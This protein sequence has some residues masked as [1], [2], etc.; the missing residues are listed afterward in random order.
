MEILIP[1]L[2]FRAQYLLV[3]FARCCGY[4]VVG[5]APAF[6]AGITGS[7]PVT[8]SMGSNFLSVGDHLIYKTITKHL[9]YWEV[10]QQRGHSRSFDVV[11]TADP[12][13]VLPDL[14]KKINILINL[15]LLEYSEDCP[16]G[17]WYLSPSTIEIET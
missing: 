4:G 10:V 15:P 17:G 9:T 3:D 6:Q 1:I 7:N 14:Y 5:N 2:Q 8:R 12:D 16:F 11:C 13:N